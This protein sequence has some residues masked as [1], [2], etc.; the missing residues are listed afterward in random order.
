M[1]RENPQELLLQDVNPF[2]LC[3]SP[4]TSVDFCRNAKALDFT[5]RLLRQ[6]ALPS[7]VLIKLAAPLAS[8]TPPA[9]LPAF[10][11]RH[12]LIFQLSR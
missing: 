4:R 10:A 3:S 5:P 11:W 8:D 1:G 12:Q 7:H 9:P 2:H 6:P